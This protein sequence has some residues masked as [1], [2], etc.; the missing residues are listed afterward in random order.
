MANQSQPFKQHHITRALKAAVKAGVD[1]QVEVRLPGGGSM[2]IGRRD[3][4]AKSDA[5]TMP[6]SSK[7]RQP[8]SRN[9][10]R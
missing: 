6:K 3:A 2:V 8:A 4:G 1:P 5:T 10:A 9:P 7:V